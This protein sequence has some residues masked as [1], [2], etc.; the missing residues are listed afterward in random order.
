MLVICDLHRRLGIGDID[1]RERH[2]R[3][4]VDNK[5]ILVEADLWL[6]SFGC[7]LETIRRMNAIRRRYLEAQSVPDCEHRR[8]ADE[9]RVA[10]GILRTDYGPGASA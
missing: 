10:L 6:I 5:I 7:G 3:D 1:Q 2:P 4:V 9:V 8:R